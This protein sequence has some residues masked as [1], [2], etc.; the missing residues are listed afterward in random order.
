MIVATPSASP[1]LPFRVSG[2]DTLAAGLNYAA[3]GE[4]GCNFFSARGELEEA[5]SYREIRDRAVDLALRLDAMGFSRGTRLALVAETSPE[6][7]IVFFACQYAGL[8]P[9]PLPLSVNFGGREAYEDRLRGMLVAAGARLAVAPADLAVVLRGAAAGTMVSHVATEEELCA[10]SA[11]DGDVRPLRADEP[12]YIQ[13]SSGSTSFPR[14]VLVT[15]QAIANNARAIARDGL[16]LVQG[17]RCASWLPLYHDMGLVGCCLT[18]VMTQVSVDFMATAAFA[19][20]PMSWLKLIAEYGGTVSFSPTFG[21]ELCVRRAGNASIG[22]LDLS[23]WRVAGIGGEMIRPRVLQ[24]FA[25]CFAPCGFDPGAFV[26]SYGLAEATLAVTFADLGRGVR[27]DWVECGD[28]LERG[29]RAAPPGSDGSGT[30]RVRAFASCGRPMPGYRVEIRDDDNMP[31]GERRIGR[32]CIQGPSLMRGYFRNLQATRT[33]TTA[34]G[35]LDT[36]DMGYF[37]DGELVITGRSK[38][39]II[40]NGRNIWP[41]DLEWAVERLDG[42]RSGDVAA[43]AITD[44]DDRE[45]VVMVVECRHT[46]PAVQHA[47]RHAAR[48][49]VQ[50]V[51]SVE[52]EVVLTQTGSLTF[53]TSGK[54]S[55]AAAKAKFLSGAIR[56]LAVPLTEGEGGELEVYAVAS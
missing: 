18:P 40:F 38:D 36:G 6:F 53:T 24:D 1:K 9:V 2:F 56:D 25:E 22:D 23:A 48:V 47:L 39:L 54:L 43:F 35:W 30:K 42:V 50:K 33:V 46:D 17:D 27:V 15:Q 31:L 26:P 19:R 55:R 5:V 10:G 16:R 32:V 14:G 34:D 51:A 20:R 21:Y 28:V 41:Q 11:K 8:I 3:K 37:V 44:E 7:M 29:R 52:C 13:Y 12:C 45:R 49:V 4:T